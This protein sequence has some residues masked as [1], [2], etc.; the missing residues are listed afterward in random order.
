VRARHRAQAAI[1][2][3]LIVVLIG[4]AGLYLSQYAANLRLWEEF[5]FGYLL[6]L[7]AY[8]W[9][10]FALLLV[11]E[12]RPHTYP[13]YAGEKIAV[14]I[15]CFNETPD[16]IEESIRTVLAAE[17]R[18]QVIVIDDGSTNGT[19]ERLLDVASE[20]GITVAFQTRNLG[21]SCRRSALRRATSSFST[22][23]RT[24]S[25]G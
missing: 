22:S 23:G 9:W 10:L 6:L 16:L 17:G 14:L 11:H 24:C 1:Y 2:V 7:V 12:A 19:Q 13:T 8:T 3:A 5:T 21:K 25:R 20:T 15:P 4:S 18:K